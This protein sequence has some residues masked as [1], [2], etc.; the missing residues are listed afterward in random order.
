VKPLPWGAPASHLAVATNERTGRFY[1]SMD[2]GI[3]SNTNL[4]VN[5]LD[6]D[7]LIRLNGIRRKLRARFFFR[8]VRQSCL[9]H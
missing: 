7:A 2:I 3:L 6:L 5:A 8:R 9:F 4:S 1:R